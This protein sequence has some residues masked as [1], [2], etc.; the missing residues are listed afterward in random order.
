MDD[1]EQRV[2][3]F[4]HEQV[5]WL[6]FDMPAGTDVVN[7]SG[8]YGEDVWDL[9]NEFAKRF[10]VGMDGFRWYHHTGEEGCNPLW[11]LIKPWWARK[12]HV[13]IR[14]FDLVESARAGVWCVL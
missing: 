3:A 5:S 14:L 13:P 2:R 10:S 7:E 6:P 9:V 11:L 4:V 8:I 12:T 1:I